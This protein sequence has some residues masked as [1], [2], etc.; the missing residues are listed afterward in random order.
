MP[1]QAGSDA[2]RSVAQLVLLDSNFRSMPKIVA[3]GRR[4]INNIER[5]ASLFLSKTIYATILAIIFVF[6]KMPYPFMPIQLSLIALVCIGIPSFIL[7]LEPNK[8]RVKG[9]FIKNVISKAMPTA[10]TTVINICIIAILCAIYEIPQ[11]IYSTLCVI[12]TVVIGFILLIKISRPFN[13]LRTIL[14]VAMISLFIGCSYV[15]EDWFSIT[16]TIEY[17]LLIIGICAMAIANFILFNEIT[18]KV[19][20]N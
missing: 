7:A 9:K 1:L 18:K 5:S 11:E 20:K 14:L 15:L 17:A 13:A 2:A 6:A 3:E 16:I 4:T 12:S 19:L 10:L 8:N